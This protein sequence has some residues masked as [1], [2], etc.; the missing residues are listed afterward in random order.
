MLIGRCL[1]RE[2]HA[3]R[4]MPTEASACLNAEVKILC[5]NLS[6]SSEGTKDSL[7]SAYFY[8]AMTS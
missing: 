1:R 8:L 5:Q 2:T 4:V 7:D 3:V 6:G